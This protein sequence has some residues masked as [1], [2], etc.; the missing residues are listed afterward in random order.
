MYENT[1]LHEKIAENINRGRNS[2][3]KVQ[4]V[5]DGDGEDYIDVAA[6]ADVSICGSLK[7]NKDASS[8]SAKGTVGVSSRGKGTGDQSSLSGA[9]DMAL[10]KELDHI[11]PGIISE[12]TADPAFESLLEEVFGK[13]LN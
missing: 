1:A 8:P 9:G 13:F 5:S 12:T 11:V 2:Q 3:N 4:V 6:N 10:L 7:K